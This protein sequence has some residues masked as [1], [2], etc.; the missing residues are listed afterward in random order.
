MSHLP[1]Q[2]SGGLLSCWLQLSLDITDGLLIPAQSL[3][4]L[5]RKLTLERICLTSLVSHT[6]A[7]DIESS[8]SFQAKP[9]TPTTKLGREEGHDAG[10]DS[11]SSG[12]DLAFLG[13]AVSTLCGELPLYYI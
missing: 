1:Y 9:S 6:N 4:E 8:C 2:L 10:S 11:D 7:G 5:V 3:S 12:R 13:L